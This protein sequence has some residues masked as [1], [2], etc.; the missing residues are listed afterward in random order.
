MFRAFAHAL[1]AG[2]RGNVG[3][4]FVTERFDGLAADWD[5]TGRVA[6]AFLPLVKVLLE[7]DRP[8]SRLIWLR[9]LNVVRLL[10]GLANRQHPAL[11]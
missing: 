9:N 4:A 8:K 3:A 2:Q 7:M 6:P 10:P 11:L 1:A 5:A